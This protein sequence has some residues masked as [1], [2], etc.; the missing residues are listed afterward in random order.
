LLKKYLKMLNNVSDIFHNFKNIFNIQIETKTFQIKL[1]SHKTL[2]PGGD[3][4][5]DQAFK[6]FSS[7]LRSREKRR[8]NDMLLERR[9]LE[10]TKENWIL[11]AQIRGVFDNYGI[12]A[13]ETLS[14]IAV[15]RILASM[16]SSEQILAFSQRSDDRRG[17]FD[18]DSSSGSGL[19]SESLLPVKRPKLEMPEPE[20]EPEPASP[21]K[22]LS[23][24]NSGSL[25]PKSEDEAWGHSTEAE[26]MRR[27]P[28]HQQTDAWGAL[29]LSSSSC[30]SND[31]VYNISASVTAGVAASVTYPLSPQSSLSSSSSSSPLST[32]HYL[33]PHKLRL[34][35]STDAATI[36]AE[37]ISD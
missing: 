22:W 7:P 2:H 20:P 25:T 36:D 13:E 15:D 8:L 5:P 29:N 17:S 26:D 1:Q 31:A 35:H 32:H 37:E 27:P 21:D 9:V 24:S 12:R 10:L 3:S 33:L 18:R 4:N 28:A 6:S 23:A 19:C 14:G 11:K 16:P 30:S 34:K